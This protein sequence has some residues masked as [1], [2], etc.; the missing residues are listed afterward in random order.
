MKATQ[1]SRVI[2][3]I[4]LIHCFAVKQGSYDVINKAAEIFNN[5]TCLKWLPY[6]PE[7]VEKV[8]HNHY[9]EFRN[10]ELVFY[11]RIINFVIT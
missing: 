9:V 5:R 1:G 8:G 3:I 6:T 7:L 2:S 10:S 11:I 4:V